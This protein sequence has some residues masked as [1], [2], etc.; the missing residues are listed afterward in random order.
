MIICHLLCYTMSLYREL[1]YGIPITD[2]D[3][4]RVGMSK[5][6]HSYYGWQL[7]GG[8]VTYRTH[9]DRVHTCNNVKTLQRIC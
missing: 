5:V 3:D 7:F 8:C 1:K 9:V 4:N 2:Q 6:S